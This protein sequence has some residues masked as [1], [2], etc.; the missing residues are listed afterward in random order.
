MA[1]DDFRQLAAEDWESVGE[2]SLEWQ[3]LLKQW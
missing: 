3:L 1:S 2:R